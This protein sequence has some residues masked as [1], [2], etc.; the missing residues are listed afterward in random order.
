MTL[1]WF[2]LT[3]TIRMPR[4]KQEFK[5]PPQ[6]S[7]GETWWRAARSWWTE[8][9]CA[10]YKGEGCPD[11][12]RWWS[13]MKYG[14]MDTSKWVPVQQGC[15]YFVSI[16]VTSQ[17]TS[18]CQI[19]NHWIFFT[20]KELTA[21]N[22]VYIKCPR[23]WPFVGGIHWWPAGTPPP[24]PTHTHTLLPLQWRHNGHHCVK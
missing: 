20:L 18:L 9:W 16:T 3:I 11:S 13:E 22:S 6:G 19:T 4:R 7:R 1:D 21:N 2:W 10:R 14:R 15:V 12:F 17:W 24:P 8:K 23:C 5:N